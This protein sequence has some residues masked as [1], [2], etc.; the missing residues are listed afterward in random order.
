MR[1]Y[2]KTMELCF[3]KLHSKV[4]GCSFKLSLAIEWLF[5]MIAASM[6]NGI[7]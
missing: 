6:L 1:W 2:D 3:K 7:T 4:R 5:P